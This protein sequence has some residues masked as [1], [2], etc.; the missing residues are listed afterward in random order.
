MQKHSFYEPTPSIYELN[1]CKK[2][3]S[4]EIKLFLSDDSGDENAA[5]EEQ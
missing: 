2:A 4:A 5:L 1:H 3:K